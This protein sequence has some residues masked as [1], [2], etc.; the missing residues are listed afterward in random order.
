MTVHTIQVP[1]YTDGNFNTKVMVSAEK[2][3]VCP[4]EHPAQLKADQ[5]TG[6]PTDT[7]QISCQRCGNCGLVEFSLV[8]AVKGWDELQQDRRPV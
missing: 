6:P 4:E 8:K 3:A 5:V 7:Y 1:L 2:C